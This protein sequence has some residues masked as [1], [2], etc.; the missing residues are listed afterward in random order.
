MVDAVT[1]LL[2]VVLLLLAGILVG[3]LLGWAVKKIL[4]AF[5]LKEALASINAEPSFLG[6][7]L[8]ELIKI[9]VEWYTYLYFIM[10]AL[11][12]MNVSALAAFIEE[13]KGMS[14][15]LIEAVVVA[16][17]GLQ[18]ANYIRK[19]LKK[20]S[21]SPYLSDLVYYVVV[22]LTIVLALTSV[23]P[24]AASMLNYLLMVLVASA[25]LGLSVGFGISL[26]LGTKEVVSKVAKKYV[27]KK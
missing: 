25:G 26:G 15:L 14:V 8:V 12:A 24:Q 23:Y 1:T 6:I 21:K 13:I 27:R 3:K 18:I 5:K 7:D 17:I 10:A 4:H 16:Y 22:Y 20:H 9:F 2:Q 11:L 19:G